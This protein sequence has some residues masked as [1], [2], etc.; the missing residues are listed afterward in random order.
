MAKSIF[1]SRRGQAAEVSFNMTPMIDCVFQLIIF[2][3]L[4]GQVASRTL[5]RVELHKPESSQAQK[6][7]EQDR[8]RVIV[9]VPS[10]AGPDSP[11][12]MSPLAS[13]AK[14]YLVAGQR[15]VPG[16]AAALEDL[17]KK[18]YEPFKE[19][20]M[21]YFVE[22]RAD[23]RVSYGH[24]HPILWAAGRAEIPKMNITALLPTR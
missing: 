7:S 6:W 19:K 21:E 22:I 1:S 13:Q 8:N 5:A 9:N 20:N 2:F 11:D 23:K 24:I 4:A 3:I 15:Y 14:E 12:Q 16:D 18:R 10:M 17:F